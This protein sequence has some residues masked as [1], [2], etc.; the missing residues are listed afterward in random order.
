MLERVLAKA[1]DDLEQTVPA[2]AELL[3][4]PGSDWIQTR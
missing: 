4:I 3:S 2:L 1:T